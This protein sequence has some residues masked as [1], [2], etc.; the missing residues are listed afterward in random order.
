MGC[1]PGGCRES[2]STEELTRFTL[3]LWMTGDLPGDSSSS[4]IVFFSSLVLLGL[5][6]ISSVH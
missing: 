4:A 3:N 5:F 6:Y 2:D 1:S